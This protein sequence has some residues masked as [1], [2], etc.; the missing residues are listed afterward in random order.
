M[1]IAQLVPVGSAPASGAAQRSFVASH[2][3]LLAA[4]L[5]L[6]A[7]LLLPTPEALPVAGHRMLALLAFAV[8][9]WMTEALDY[10]V[11]AVV[12]AALM[13]FLLG[14]APNPANPAT[15]MGTSAGL[16]VAFSG[17]ANTALALV[18]SALFL[19]A[20][21][22][23]TG[24]DKRIALVIL[25]RVGTD[26]RHVVAGSILVGIV[27][28]FL[29][30]STTARVSCLVPIT[31]GIIAAFGVNKK[32]A[33]AGMLMITTTQTA[34][35]WNV[36]IKTAAAQNM[37]AVGFIEKAFNTTI[38]WLEWLV[39]AGPFAILMSLALYVV[40]TRM[41]PPELAT[42]PG[43]REAIRKALA[44]LGP[45][46]MSEK[47]LLAISLTL[48]G[49]W[50]TEGVLHRFDTSTT[51]IAA[52]ALMFMPGIGI[53]TWKEAQPKI[54]WGTVV[55]FGIGISLGTALLQTKGAVWLADLAV[56]EFG[57]K[58]ATA[59]FILMVMSL[60]LILIHLGFASATALASAMIPI[61]IAVLQGVATPGINK[62]GM[63]VLLQ[64]V[65]SFGF[66]LVVNAPQN[67][68]AYGTETFEARDFVRTGLV[69]TLVAFVLV[70]LLGA[71]YWHWLGYV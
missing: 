10:A 24:L 61:V 33:F 36:G 28:A 63:T 1:S 52:V 34:S 44:E 8:I 19:A 54:P 27:I 18:A 69:L 2:W 42:V 40:M 43:G 30:P 67:M 51:T 17:F 4:V 62:V 58:Q 50:A 59:L 46:K 25:S 66:I 20:A 13:A 35:I 41:M 60:F 6:L 14:T 56:A 47:K 68:V 12:I 71:T 37:V 15:L 38:T 57:L 70:M 22:T 7:V 29:V 23:A 49:F 26:V 16:G 11:S 48:L 5:L 64:F 31:L 65:V 32:G 45:M 55:L 21:M 39:A 9:V 3:G 53:M